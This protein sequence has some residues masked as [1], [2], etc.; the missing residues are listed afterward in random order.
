MTIQFNGR[1]VAG[2]AVGAPQR[3]DVNRHF[4]DRYSIPHAALGAIFEAAGLPP[5]L[6]IGSHIVFEAIE[7]GLKRVAE[8]IWPDS[9][10]DGWQNHVGDMVSFTGGL[11][12]A[13]ALKETEGGKVVLTGFVAAAGA[14]WMW[15]LV[16]K[17]SWTQK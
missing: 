8:P 14:I 6:S 3:D 4:F 15:N 16:Q 17:H 9:R 12:A 5:A 1:P 10:P 13:K 2:F 11:A 7:N